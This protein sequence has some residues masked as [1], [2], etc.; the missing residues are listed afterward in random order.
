MQ[1][2]C[3]E[4]ADIMLQLI[5]ILLLIDLLSALALNPKVQ[6]TSLIRIIAVAED[7]IEL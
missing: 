3:A 6:G 1:P 7:G 4:T 5:V 2:V